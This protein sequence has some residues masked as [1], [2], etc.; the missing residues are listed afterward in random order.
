MRAGRWVLGTA[1]A[2]TVATA[3]PKAGAVTSV[4]AVQG[5]DAQLASTISASLSAASVNLGTISSNDPTG[6]ANTA[7]AG[8]ISI[9]ANVGYTVTVASDKVAMTEW[10]GSVYASNPK[11]LAAALA[12]RCS[13]PSGTGATCT[14]LT[15]TSIL[16]TGTAVATSA[17]STGGATHTYTLTLSQ[18]TTLA[19]P[20]ATYHL[21]LTYT[22]TT[23][24]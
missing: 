5:L 20:P 21:V 8:T 3:V 19:D 1:A 23:L 10:T 17:V 6:A 9:T 7:A 2:L 18:P 24:L 16:T 22:A 13:A 15:A 12:V 14:A 4:T 11:R